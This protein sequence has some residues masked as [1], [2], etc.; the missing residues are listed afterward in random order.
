MNRAQ[1]EELVKK[2]N[3]GTA[4][5]AEINLLDHWYVH[6]SS[7]QSNNLQEEDYK[8]I[9]DEM[10]ANI[11]M[12][13]Q[14]EP[15]NRL[16]IKLAVAVCLLICFGAGIFLV[17]S[18]KNNQ[19]K[20]EAQAANDI[21]P[22]KNGATL[23]LSNGER[24]VLEDKVNG[25]ITSQAGTNVIQA[26]GK[27]IYESI[28]T[29]DVGAPTFNTLLT[30]KGQQYE[31]LLPDGTH[32]WLNSETS[33]KFPANFENQSI[34]SV[35]LNGQAYFEVKKDSQHPFVVNIGK[36]KVEVLGTHFD[37]YNYPDETVKTT[38]LEGSVSVSKI[39]NNGKSIRSKIL[40]PGEQAI[41]A[42][43]GDVF[44][45][46]DVETERVIAWKNGFFEFDNANVK[47]VMHQ[48]SRWYDIEVEYPAAIP[49]ETFSGKVY[50]NMSLSKV[51]EVL[52]F[53]QIDFEIKGRK[54]TIFSHRDK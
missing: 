23:V 26:A 20:H 30:K 15:G 4:S 52:S 51:L 19:I 16:W 39:D 29:K 11:H 33:L 3:A 8:L 28:A 12:A 42:K 27:L 7:I 37:I 50:R 53:S 44:E 10:W 38:L 17:L 31:L 40:K 35:E 5:Q 47:A 14:K 2:Y 49:K 43:N 46:N 45:I 48:L 21:A 24:I 36:Q 54:M 34:R 25:T 9:V 22:G 18:E 13:K 41:L 6:Q 1:A 32:V